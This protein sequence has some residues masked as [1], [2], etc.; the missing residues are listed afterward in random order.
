MKTAKRIF[1]RPL[2]VNDYLPINK[3]RND[4]KIARYLAGNAYLVS[5]ER[6]KRWV[7]EKIADNRDNLYFAICAAKAGRLIG[8]SSI[9]HIDLR[10]RKAEWGGTL[11]G[12]RSCIG[13][14]YG[15]EAS[16]LMLRYLF[17]QYPVHRCYA[18][19][20]QEHPSTEKLFL[21]RGFKREGILRDDVFKDGSFKNLLLFS[22]LRHEIEDHF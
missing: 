1:L 17:D 9:N 5:P 18:Y 7:E 3:W 8:Y 15:R 20:L 10:N 2:E 11:V 6:E 21:S 13:K 12:D 4:P 22:I 19:C 16:S 14:G